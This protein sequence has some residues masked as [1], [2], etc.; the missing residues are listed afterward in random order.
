MTVWFLNSQESGVSF[1]KKVEHSINIGSVADMPEFE[2][3][4]KIFFYP[5]NLQGKGRTIRKM[6][7]NGTDTG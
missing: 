2:L 3:K 5:F 4:V 6:I 1:R 7:N